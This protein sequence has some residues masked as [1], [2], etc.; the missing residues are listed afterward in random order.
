MR[1]P[2]VRPFV[3]FFLALSLSILLAACGGEEKTTTGE[4]PGAGPSGP[5]SIDFWHSE[6][7]S[8][9]ETLQRLVASYNSSQNEV[10]VREIYQGD[11]AEAAAKLITSLGTGQVPALILMNESQ[12]Q[13]MID[14]GAITPAKQFI[15]EEDYDLSDIDEKAVKYYT[16]EDSLRAMPF[17]AEMPLLYYNKTVYR[18]VGL[19]PETP[20]QNLEI[21]RQ[22]SEKI[23]KRDASGNVVRSGIALDIHG[24]L[25]TVLAEDGDLWVNESNGHDGRATE[26]QF[27]NDAGRYF[28]Q[29]W[30]DMVDSGLAFNVGRNPTYAD[31]F[32]A[33]ASGRAAMTFSYAGA[34]RSVVDALEKGVEG[35]EIGVARLPGIPDSTSEDLNGFSIYGLWILNQ[36]PEQE[37][38]AAW[39]F[40][41]WLT[42]PEQQAEWFAGTGYLPVSRSSVDLPAAKDALSSYPLFEVPL[43]LYFHTPATPATSG[44]ILGPADQVAEIV[45]TAVEEM[46]VGNKEPAQALKDAAT[47]AD[48]ALTQ[49]NERVA[50]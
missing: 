30:H 11:Y 1:K 25:S 17:C 38:Q 13:R 44:A 32:L 2:S 29:W 37:Q 15:D 9:V 24:W 46:L 28:F 6:V 4:T 39:K 5:V 26:V 50:H 14:S 33:M 23:L 21:L 45:Y 41:K 19:D 48:Q 40:V 36:R 31:D 35:V 16:V 18:E 49:Y 43:S 3:L 42:E 22:Y 47:K 7:G 20:P 8:N 27:D 34:L 12:I 10:R